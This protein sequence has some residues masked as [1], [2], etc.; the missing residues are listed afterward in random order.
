MVLYFDLSQGVPVY[1]VDDLSR[2]GELMRGV[3]PTTMTVV[4]RLL[5]RVYEKMR[6]GVEE[7]KGFRW[8]LGLAACAEPRLKAAAPFLGIVD[9]VE[10]AGPGR[11]ALSPLEEAG[12]RRLD[13]LYA[14]DGRP[15]A[16]ILAQYGADDAITSAGLLARFDRRMKSLYA[17]TP[18]RF[19]PVRHPGVAHEM[20][21]R[22][23]DNALEWFG[24]YL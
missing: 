21:R 6:L 17:E 2:I 15:A 18:G 4:P 19:R 16:A 7:A 14:I 24:R 5:E 23:I 20:S 11:P 9:L 1:F 10:S 22:M 12:V 13:P 8:K 3:R